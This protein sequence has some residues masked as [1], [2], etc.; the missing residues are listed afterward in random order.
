MIASLALAANFAA[1]SDSDQTAAFKLD[2]ESETAVVS[3]YSGVT[4]TAE[5]GDASTEAGIP[6]SVRESE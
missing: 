1:A 6:L 2:L 5:I 4:T 3:Y